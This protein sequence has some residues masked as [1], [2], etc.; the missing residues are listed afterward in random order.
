MNQ[1]IEYQRPRLLRFD[2]IQSITG[3]SRTFHYDKIK[4]GLMT[5]PV[6]VGS[7]ASAWPAHEI[8]AITTARIAGKSEAEIRALVARLEAERRAA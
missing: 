3:D 2:T 1:A 6:K 8:E 5:R 7:R 4:R